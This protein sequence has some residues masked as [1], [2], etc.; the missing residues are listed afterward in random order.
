MKRNIFRCHCGA[1]RV[2]GSGS[3]V[4]VLISTVLIRPRL[5]CSNPDHPG[6]HLHEY[7]RSE[8]GTWLEYTQVSGVE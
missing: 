2:Y 8:P 3:E 5:R 7:V 4:D 6:L 1:E